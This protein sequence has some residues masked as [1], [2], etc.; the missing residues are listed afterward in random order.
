MKTELRSTPTPLIPVTRPAAEHLA[1]PTGQVELPLSRS[2]PAD[3]PE[4]IELI[5]RDR[6]DY[7]VVRLGDLV[8]T[9][10]THSH[11]ASLVLPY[12]PVFRSAPLLAR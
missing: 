6:V 3:S 11:G 1:L 8:Q 12:E 4:Q 9:K 10:L 2:E 7:D 5:A